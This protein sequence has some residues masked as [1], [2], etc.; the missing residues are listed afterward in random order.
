MRYVIVGCGRMGA[1]LALALRRGGHDFAFVD[2]G[3]GAAE[4]LEPSLRGQLV[5]GGCFDRDTLVCAGIEQADGLAAV[6]G[7]DETNVVVARLARLVFRVPRVVA[8]LHDPQNA[9]IYRRLGVQVV[10]PHDWAVN[11]IAD[12]LLYAESEVLASLGDGQAEIVCFPVPPPLEGRQTGYLTVF[13]EMHVVAVGRRGR[14]LLPSSETAFERDDTVYV[15]V[16]RESSERLRSIL[17]LT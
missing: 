11:R 5:T 15:A 9:E 16:L 3:S 12:Q 6:T 10:A 4:G 14:I 13:G 17:A 8:G 7:N 1:G 2:D